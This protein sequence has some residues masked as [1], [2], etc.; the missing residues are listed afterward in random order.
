MR[1][2]VLL[3]RTGV[4][5]ALGT[6]GGLLEGHWTDEH[7]RSGPRDAGGNRST[8]RQGTTPD[9]EPPTIELYDRIVTGPPGGVESIDK[10]TDSG[11]T[12]SGEVNGASPYHRVLVWNDVGEERSL[13]VSIERTDGPLLRREETS[14]PAEGLLEILLFERREEDE[15]VAHGLTVETS[16]LQEQLSIEPASIRVGGPE[17]RV[18]VREESIAW[19]SVD[20]P[21]EADPPAVDGPVREA[22][23]DIV[24]AGCATGAD[25]DR[26]DVRVEDATVHIRGLIRAPT[27]CHGVS[28]ASV[29]RRNESD[30]EIVVAVGEQE[31]AVCIQCIGALTYDA[32]VALELDPFDRVTIVH[33]SWG[34]RTD[35]A[36]YE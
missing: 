20:D 25:D 35:V 3:E 12:D 27:P 24:E 16:R 23:L 5:F 9:L 1:R 22:R 4:G 6:A 28:I 31:T 7:S 33:E 21:V 34:E 32:T 15:R 10:E 26:A 18:A 8:H 14:F 36:V 29:Q 19:E 2:R 11:V 17:T 13:D 30:V